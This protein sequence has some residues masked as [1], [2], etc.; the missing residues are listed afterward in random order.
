MPTKSQLTVTLRNAEKELIAH[1]AV[2]KKL[3]T[4]FE[5]IREVNKQ[6]NVRHEET[7]VSWKQFQ[8]LKIDNKRCTDLH[9]ATQ[10]SNIETAIQRDEALKELRELRERFTGVAKARDAQANLLKTNTDTIHR[11][12]QELVDTRGMTLTMSKALQR[13][14]ENTR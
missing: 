1:K 3:R 14:L 10:Q 9:Q 12:M 4:D 8:K 7:A 6:M 2:N 13:I 11:L 5:Y